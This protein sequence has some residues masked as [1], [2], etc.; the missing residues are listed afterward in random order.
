MFAGVLVVLDG[1]VV[2]R[3][4]VRLDTEVHADTVGGVDLVRVRSL[5]LFDFDHEAGEPRAGS[6]LLE[7]RAFDV[8]GVRQ[9]AVSANRYLADFRESER[10]ELLARRVIAVETFRLV[11]HRPNFARPLPLEPSGLATILPVLKE[12]LQILV[13]LTHRLLAVW[14]IRPRTST[15]VVSTR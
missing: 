9:V 6:I 10:T 1:K 13:D 12:H 4:N 5:G 2:A 7:N 14:P 15:T 8:L 3:V 11:R